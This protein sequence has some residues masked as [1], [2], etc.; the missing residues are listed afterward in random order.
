LEGRENLFEQLATLT[1][2]KFEREVPTAGP[3]N[4]GIVANATH[5][6]SKPSL[7]ALRN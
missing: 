7:A 3:S 4:G 2:E 5:V 1:D 6:S